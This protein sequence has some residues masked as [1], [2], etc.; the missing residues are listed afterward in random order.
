VVTSQGEEYAADVVIYGT[1]FQTIQH[2]PINSRIRG[3]DGRTLEEV[4]AGSPTAYLG[5]TVAGYPNVFTMFGPNIGTLSGFVMAEAQ[6]DYLVGALTAMRKGGLAS[7]DVKPE[8]QA[9][10]VAR[11]D[12]ALK[13]S[14]FAVGGCSSYYLDDTE[15]RVTLVWPWSMVT[16][17]RRLKRFDL[18]VYASV[19]RSHVRRLSDPAR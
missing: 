19:A 4:W 1:G 12:E 18:A 2:H 13:G 8:A 14:T 3:R 6:T 9:A 16:M 17:R 11:V 7:I 15:R 10:F 5:T